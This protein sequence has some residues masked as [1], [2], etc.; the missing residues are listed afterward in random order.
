MDEETLDY[1][2]ELEMQLFEAEHQIEKRDLEIA[3]LARANT[4]YQEQLE[5]YLGPL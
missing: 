2:H 5:Q 3:R 1:I 4:I